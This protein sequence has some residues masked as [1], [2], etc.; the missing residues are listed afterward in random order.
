MEKVSLMGVPHASVYSWG[1]LAVPEKCLF[2]EVALWVAEL[3]SSPKGTK[4]FHAD[5]DVK[6]SLDTQHLERI[7]NVI[8]RLGTQSKEIIS[9]PLSA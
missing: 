2:Q 8:E 1:S 9:H 7:H 5:E 6:H 4:L 3:I